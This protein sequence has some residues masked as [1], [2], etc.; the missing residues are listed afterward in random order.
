MEIPRVTWENHTINEFILLGLLQ[1]TPT[2]LCL[3]ALITIIFLFM[4]TGNGL[5]AI[6]ILVDTCL[7][8]PMD[9]SLWSCLSLMPSLLSPLYPRWWWTTLCI[10]GSAL[11]LVVALRSSCGWLWEE[12][13]VSSW[14]SCPMID[15]V[16]SASV[17]TS[18]S[19]WTGPSVGRWHF[20]HGPV[21]LSIPWS[22]LS[23]PWDSPLVDP[24]KSTI[25]TMNFLVLH[26]SCGDTFTYEI[27]FSLAPPFCFL[28][29][30]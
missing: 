29:H 2:H 6:V 16:L 5:L 13:S 21:V 8:T 23:T 11:L 19:S 15:M 28:F 24:D 4:L 26:L 10:K 12:L 3:F 25:S 14:V 27:G 17:Y 1:Y 22:I 18:R 30:F 20:V 9:F 7:H